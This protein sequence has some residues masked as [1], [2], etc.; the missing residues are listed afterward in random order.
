MYLFFRKRLAFSPLK[1]FRYVYLNHFSFG[2]I[3][4]DRFAVYAGKKFTFVID[5]REQFENLVSRKE[6]FLQLSSHVGNYELAG[7][8]LVAKEKR[9]NALVFS[10][11]TETVM[12]NREKVLSRNNIRMIPVE[13]NM[14]H[15]FLLNNAL[16]NG[17]IVSMPGDRIFGSPRY[18][19]CPF[20]GEKAKFPLGP[21]AIA[22]QRDVR[23][24]AV[25]VM[26]ESVNKYRIFVRNV[27]AG[28]D[29][30]SRKEKIAELAETF[31]VEL[32]KVVRMYP[33]Q[34]FNYYDFW[35]H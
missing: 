26:K 3:I 29:L 8:S 21:F 1:A 7:Y 32:E 25:F 11:E 34:W 16:N 20:F 4:L 35:S 17:E 13:E 19:E 27:S 28:K 15:V 10:G 5:G 18:V 9:F 30:F 24:L 22:T 23:I 14:L 31:A 6:G 33:T 12:K 2:Q